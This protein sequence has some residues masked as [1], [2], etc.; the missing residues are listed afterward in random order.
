ML[1]P[2]ISIL[3]HEISAN[4]KSNAIID[5][6]D[7][8]AFAS[9]KFYENNPI[10]DDKIDWDKCVSNITI[11]DD[12]WALFP[13]LKANCRTDLEPPN[14]IRE[15]QYQFIIRDLSHPENKMFHKF[16]AR[17]YEPVEN[18]IVEVVAEGDEILPKNV[19][20]VAIRVFILTHDPPSLSF[21]FNI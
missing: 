14:Q 8:S 2:S 9:T 3:E 6:P 10:E 4:L 16:G 11:T 20:A 21:A 5:V 1:D 12:F 17:L 19:E 7:T 18:E 15:F 13:F